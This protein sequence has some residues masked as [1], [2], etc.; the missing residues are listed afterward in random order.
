VALFSAD[1]LT[2]V[3]ERKILEAM[4]EGQ[5][6]DLPGRGRPQNL[7][8]LSGIPEDSRLAYIILKNAGYAAP[9]P[10]EPQNSRNLLADSPEEAAAFR[11]LAK[12]KT[13][14][15]AKSQGAL[16]RLSQAYLEKILA[17]L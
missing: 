9:N 6:D 11:R 10:E 14:W 15:P 3:A 4:E 16:D 8:D 1:I 7:E 5:F 12:L 2:V 13:R 17:K